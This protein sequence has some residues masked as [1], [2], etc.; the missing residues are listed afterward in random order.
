MDQH[1][2]L[3]IHGFIFVRQLQV[4]LCQNDIENINIQEIFKIAMKYYHINKLKRHTW[5]SSIP[6]MWKALLKTV[7]HSFYSSFF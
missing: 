4:L 7:L 2:Y 1:I 5:K 3:S 6:K